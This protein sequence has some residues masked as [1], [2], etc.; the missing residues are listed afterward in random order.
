MA[1]QVYQRKGWI[2]HG[3]PPE[4]DDLAGEFSFHTPGSCHNKIEKL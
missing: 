4:G 2:D 3:Q 1:V